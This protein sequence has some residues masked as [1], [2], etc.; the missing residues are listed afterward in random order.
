MAVV[1]CN[2]HNVHSTML[3][4][5]EAV[6]QSDVDITPLFFESY[7]AL[8]PDHRNLFY[9]RENTAGLMLNEIIDAQLGLAADELWVCQSMIDIVVSHRGHGD[10]SLG[11]YRDI[12]A[13]LVR[14]FAAVAGS[15]W[16]QEFENVWQAQSEKM[17]AMIGSA[18]RL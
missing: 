7:F 17:L 12:L 16:T 1:P 8:Y 6:A 18:L 14:T 4:S 10:F 2:A 13:T 9:D 15:R 11:M 3:E 5:L